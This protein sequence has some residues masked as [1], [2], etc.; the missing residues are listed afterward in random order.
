MKIDIKNIL[1]SYRR[2]KCADQACP[3]CSDK[4]GEYAPLVEIT[5]FLARHNLSLNAKNLEQAWEY[6]CGDNE[7]LKTELERASSASELN[8]QSALEIYEKYFN[9]DLNERMEKIFQQAV[10]QICE[11]TQI[12]SA[13]NDEA[14]RHENAAT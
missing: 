10:E 8:N 11:T 5:N 6:V 7:E 12:M 14:I 4:D 1:N 9:V 2:E 3:V 13:G